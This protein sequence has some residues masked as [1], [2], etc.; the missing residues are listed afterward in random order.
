M[1]TAYRLK[2]PRNQIVRRALELKPSAMYGGILR[3]RIDLILVLLYALPEQLK[4][5]QLSILGLAWVLKAQ[6]ARQWRLRVTQV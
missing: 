5:T 1:Q 4:I 3:A 2:D 6:L